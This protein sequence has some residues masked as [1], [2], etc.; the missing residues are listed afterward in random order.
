MDPLCC[1]YQ[2]QCQR[3]HLGKSKVSFVKCIIG[4]FIWLVHIVPRVIYSQL[5]LA[6]ISVSNSSNRI[7]TVQARTKTTTIRKSP[8]KTV[9]QKKPKSVAASPATKISSTVHRPMVTTN[10]SRT[11]IRSSRHTNPPTATTRPVV[12]VVNP[13]RSSSIES[14]SVATPTQSYSTGIIQSRPVPTIR[15]GS[16]KVNTSRKGEAGLPDTIKLMIGAGGIY[17]SFLYYGSLQEDVFRYTSS[18]GTQFRQA[19]FLQVLEA[20]ANVIVGFIGMTVFGATKDIPLNMLGISGVAQGAFL[21]G[22]F[23]NPFVRNSMI[24]TKIIIS[25]GWLICL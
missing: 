17:A 8:T 25:I 3:T 6:T 23:P 10:P 16:N 1:K 5:T 18:N 22:I 21:R 9:A 15:E 4:I 20:L 11:S 19:W 24:L 13:T 7:T 2:S 12:V 14:H